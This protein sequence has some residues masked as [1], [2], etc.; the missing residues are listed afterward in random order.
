MLL[1]LWTRI[2]RNDLIK[3]P[4]VKIDMFFNEFFPKYGKKNLHNENI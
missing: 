4:K 2:D 1:F 3:V